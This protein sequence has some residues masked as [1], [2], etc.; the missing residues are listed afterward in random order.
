MTKPCRLLEPRGGGE[1]PVAVHE[2]PYGIRAS[3][4]WGDVGHQHEPRHGGGDWCRCGWRYG[5]R[6]RR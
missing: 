5:L 3:T 4:G 2:P 1:N 6:T